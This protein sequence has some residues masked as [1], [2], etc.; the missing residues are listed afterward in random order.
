VNG[1]QRFGHITVGNSG[2]TGV[3]MTQAAF[4]QANRVM[5]DLMYNVVGPMFYYG[6]PP[7]VSL[8]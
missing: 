7:E 3:S 4:D 8:D 1:S 5:K 2:A 6:N